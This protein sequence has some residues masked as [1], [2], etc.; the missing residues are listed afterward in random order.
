MV[1]RA[2]DVPGRRRPACAARASLRARGLLP[3][4]SKSGEGPRLGEDDHAAWRAL[5]RRRGGFRRTDRRR[6]ARRFPDRRRRRPH[7]VARRCNDRARA[8]M[9]LLTCPNCG[10]AAEETEFAPGGEAHVRREGPGS[11]DAAFADYLFTRRTPA[12]CISNAGGTSTAAASGSTSRAAP[13][14]WRCSEATP[15]RSPVRPPE[16]LEAIRARRPGWE[17]E[18]MSRRLAVGGARIDRARPLRFPWNG[19]ALTGFHGD[20]LASALLANGETLVGRSFKYHRPRGVVAS[21]VEEPNALV[22]LGTGGAFEPN[23]RA[24]TDRARRGPR[25]AQP[26][27][28]AEPRARRRRARRPR[29][30]RCCRPASTTRPSS[31][32]RAAWKHLFEP[33]IRRSA[34]LGAAPTRPDPDRYDHRY[35]FFDVVVAGGGLAGLAAAR[36][37]AAAGARV[38]LAEQDAAFG[39][40]AAVDGDRVAGASGRRLDRREPLAALR[41]VAERDA[42]D[43]HDDRRRSADHGYVLAAERRT[44]DGPRERLWR[45][46]ARRIV[47]ATGAIERPLAFAGNDLPGRDA[48]LG[49]ARLPRALGRGAGRAGRRRHLRRRRLSHRAGAA[50]R[51]GS[52]SRPCSTRAPTRRATCRTRRAPPACAC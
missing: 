33:L 41:G 39:G 21:G 28:L 31:Q 8:S 49:R 44:G 13:R 26:E 17:P 24:T 52:R 48:G 7:P 35:A 32:P 30:R 22:G 43:P 14:R 37:A 15:R 45:I 38:L 12:A 40:R 27:P 19:R 11:S 5:R 47:S 29:R 25:G 20:T 1:R 50:R 46:R 3:A 2:A 42:A 18:R 36:A 34:G 4:R 16:I 6:T 9:L 23:A 51:P 10:V